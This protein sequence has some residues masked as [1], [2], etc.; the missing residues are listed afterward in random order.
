MQVG[1]HS[2]LSAA[3]R[4]KPVVPGAAQQVQEIRRERCDEDERRGGRPVLQVHRQWQRD[5]G[6]HERDDRQVAG[7]SVQRTQ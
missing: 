2:Q 1:P 4:R 6:E 3:S 7:L 5:N